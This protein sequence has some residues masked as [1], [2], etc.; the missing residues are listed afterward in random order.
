MHELYD[1]RDGSGVG[2]TYET[3][4][5]QRQRSGYRHPTGVRSTSDMSDT[6]QTSHARELEPALSPPLTLSQ[7]VSLTTSDLGHSSPPGTRMGDG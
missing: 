6:K 3:Q 7:Q 4:Q 1:G 5:E 2:T